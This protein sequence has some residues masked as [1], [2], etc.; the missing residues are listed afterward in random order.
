MKILSDTAVTNLKKIY[1]GN[2]SSDLS[3]KVMS[4]VSYGS[5]AVGTSGEEMYA[6]AYTQADM[7]KAVNIIEDKMLEALKKLK[8][9]FKLFN[10]ENRSCFAT[11]P[12]CFE[13]TAIRTHRVRRKKYRRRQ[14]SH[15]RR[16][17]WRSRH[18][19]RGGRY[20]V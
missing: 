5:Y 17:D 14:S 8:V 9:K 16:K 13:L 19:R 7:K 20:S 2:T 1:I 15:G 12:I 18:R 10:I 3:Q 11:A 4:E 6:V